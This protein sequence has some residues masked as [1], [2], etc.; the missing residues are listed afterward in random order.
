ME[1]VGTGRWATPLPVP[2]ESRSPRET[3][4]EDSSISH[5]IPATWFRLTLYSPVQD[6][7][8][9]KAWLGPVW[10]GRYWPSGMH[11]CHIASENVVE[12]ME[13]C[14]RV[15]QQISESSGH[16]AQPGLSLQL[17]KGTKV[18]R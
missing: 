17:R 15:S 4:R 10:S 11:H 9:P 6:Q 12:W 2:Q 7:V 3:M 8:V 16:A 5:D 14:G 13:E 1:R 18:G